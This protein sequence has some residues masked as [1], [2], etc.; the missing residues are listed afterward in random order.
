MKTNKP[1]DENDPSTYPVMSTQFGSH[2]IRPTEFNVIDDDDFTDNPNGI[3]PMY[4][5]NSTK[6]N[7][8]K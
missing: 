2:S 6:F 5:D 8:S 7:K 1:Y 3:I 4:V